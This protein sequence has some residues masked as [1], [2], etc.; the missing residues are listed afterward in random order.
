L[1]LKIPLTTMSAKPVSCHQTA[2][3][4]STD[5]KIG[6]RTWS[7]EKLAIISIFCLSLVCLIASAIVYTR[8]VA[9]YTKCSDQNSLL[10]S[11]INYCTNT[12]PQA[13]RS[14]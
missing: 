2:G 3:R 10:Q 1:I 13:S 14:F 6:T 8:A 9:L 11:T 4:S 5:T 7:A 12:F